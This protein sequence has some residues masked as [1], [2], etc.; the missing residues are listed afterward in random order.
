MSAYAF[1]VRGRLL[2]VV[3]E[4]LVCMKSAVVARKRW[5]SMLTLHGNDVDDR[6]R[7]LTFIYSRP[8]RPTPAF[9]IPGF[10]VP[11]SSCFKSYG[12]QCDVPSSTYAILY[13]SYSLKFSE[14]HNSSCHIYKTSPREAIIN[15]HFA[16]AICNTNLHTHHKLCDNT[17]SVHLL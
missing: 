1:L 5:L 15:L 11:R 2:K 17:T 14:C 16:T 8:A 6:A 3:Q 13:H 4:V 9:F 12:T 10:A 7:D